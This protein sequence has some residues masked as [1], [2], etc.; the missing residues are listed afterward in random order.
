MLL[1]LLSNSPPQSSDFFS[2]PVWQFLSGIGAIIAIP[3][4]IVAA[5]VAILAYR[6]QQRQREL[7]YQII[8]DAPVV[9]VNPNV[10]DKVQI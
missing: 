8:S 4:A 10:K 2:S 7:T 1:I 5:I 6:N 3:I 9:T